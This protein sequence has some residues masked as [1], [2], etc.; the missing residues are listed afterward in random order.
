MLGPLVE[1]H[2]ADDTLNESEVDALTNKIAVIGAFGLVATAR[3]MFL[4]S[5]Y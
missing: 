5:G 3:G 4:M 1:P 2:D